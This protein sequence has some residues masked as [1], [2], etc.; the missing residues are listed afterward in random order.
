M[1]VVSLVTWAEG[2]LV[3]AGASPTSLIPFPPGVGHARL[4]SMV[5]STLVS[6]D[7]T[8]SRLSLYP[9]GLSYLD[10]QWCSLFVTRTNLA[11]GG[12]VSLDGVKRST[13]QM[14]PVR[15]YVPWTRWARWWFPPPLPR[16][17]SCLFGVTC[18]PVR[19]RYFSF[20]L[21]GAGDAP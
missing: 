12:H 17:P 5:G 2:P 7:P 1:A 15:G 3:R 6:I 10:L 8:L 18:G 13:P 4:P 11:S 20:R 16:R 21:C 19:S 14:A 9:C